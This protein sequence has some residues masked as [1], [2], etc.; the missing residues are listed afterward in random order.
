MN[1][2]LTSFLVALLAYPVPGSSQWR[3][4]GAV[5]SFSVASDRSLRVYS[6]GAVVSIEA[7]GDAVMR[8]R[9]APD[10]ELR[11]NLT[12]PIVRPVPVAENPTVEERE[13]AVVFKNALLSVEVSR[14]R[15][16]LR[17]LDHA[18][19]VLSADDPERGMAWDGKAVRVWKSMPEQENY[20]GFGLKSG[21][22]NKKYSHLTMWNSDIPAYG[23]DTDP[24]YESIPFFLAVKGGVAHGTFFHN[25]FWSSF[26]MGKESRDR[27][28]FGAEGGD[29][30]YYIIA[31]PDPK[32]VISRYTALVGRMPLPPLWSL[33]YQQCRW[34]YYPEERV[35][36]LA[37]T[38]REK[39][40]P[41]DV[42]YLDIDYMEGYRIFTWSQKNFPRPAPMIAD[43]AE[44]GFKVAVILDPGIKLDTAYGAYRTGLAGNHF[45]KYPDGRLFIGKV[46]PGECAF[47]DFTRPETR[48]WW[49]EQL[50]ALVD[51][52][53][54]GFWNDMNE[55]SVFDVPTKTVALEVVHNDGGRRTSHTRNHNTYGL[56]MTKATR[57]G[58]LSHRPGERPFVLT[59]A[60]FAGGQ[61][62]SA[63]WT[64]DNVAS[65]EHLQ[66][67]LPMCLNLGLSGQP[68]VGS[69]IGG[70]IGSPSGELYA[71]WLQLGVFMPLMRTHTVAGSAPQ[72]PW[73]YGEDFERINRSTIELRYRLLPYIYTV[74]HQASET[75]LPAMRPMILEHPHATEASW[76]QEQF[77]FG[78]HLL[79]APVLWPGDTT[80][81]LWLPEGRWFDFWERKVHSGPASVTLQAPIDRIPIL[82]RAG[83]VIPLQPVMQF[84]GETPADPLTL[85]VCVGDS[86]IAHYY[87]DD[88]LSFDYTRG[89][90]AR[91]TVKQVSSATMHVIRVSAAQGSYR[92]ARKGL[93]L[94]IWGFEKRPLDVRA[95]TSGTGGRS[96]LQNWRFDDLTRRLVV[97][98]PEQPLSWE[99]VIER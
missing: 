76:N 97:A 56:L 68:F 21:R 39:K 59:R 30:D 53:V 18:G 57:E 94:E 8:I 13:D 27:Y 75:G 89:V 70:F 86:S 88:G 25:S 7:L 37:R 84:V 80:R 43:L 41:A 14:A 82:V 92:P 71:R 9:L 33:G 32:D 51:V 85:L 22:M 40:I 96:I 26:D 50:K 42:I 44:Q 10:G 58:V 77:Y 28:S 74:M 24:L 93:E 65:W 52:G 5:D 95:V 48:T 29:L 99:V 2:V 90:S 91:R 16:R 54:R 64:G 6:S 69:D 45:L 35:R 60:T 55:P 83:G 62:Y 36:E 38:F 1:R 17:V 72:E 87:E 98:V 19:R 15:L 4:L 20:Y 49:A 34:S 66:M 12:E 31:G 23:A 78:D 67:T 73:S 11:A 46:W 61:S 81:Q 47:P 79:V 3:S 63:A